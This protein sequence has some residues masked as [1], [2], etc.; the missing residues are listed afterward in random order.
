MDSLRLLSIYIVK[1][2]WKKMEWL[3]TVHTPPLT[4]GDLI[5][6]VGGI[7]KYHVEYFAYY[8]GIHGYKR[9]KHKVLTV[10]LMDAY[11]RLPQQSYE[12]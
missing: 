10:V 11:Y 4:S 3:I 7:Q 2:Y 5:K 12:W 6:V 9:P 8:N 1:L